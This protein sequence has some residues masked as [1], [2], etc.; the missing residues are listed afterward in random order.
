MCYPA[1][2]TNLIPPVLAG[3]TV[4]LMLYTGYHLVECGVIT[5]CSGHA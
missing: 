3:E 1:P 5:L 4:K 2:A